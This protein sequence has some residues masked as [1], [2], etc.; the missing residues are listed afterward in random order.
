MVCVGVCRGETPVLAARA[1]RATECAVE[2]FPVGTLPCLEYGQRQ[3]IGVLPNTHAR[4]KVLQLDRLRHRH[5]SLLHLR[6]EHIDVLDRESGVT[7]P[8][9]DVIDLARQCTAWFGLPQGQSATFCGKFAP[10]RRLMFKWKPNDVAVEGHASRHI[11][12][13][14]DG[15]TQRRHLGKCTIGRPERQRPATVVA[16]RESCSLGEGRQITKNWRA[17]RDSNSRPI[18]PEA[19][20]LSS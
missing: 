10:T 15:V 14:N 6:G 17:R 1:V 18:A 20:A 11:R 16:N 8:G 5:T 12:H 7:M 13:E 9:S 19:I 4:S 2:A 3:P